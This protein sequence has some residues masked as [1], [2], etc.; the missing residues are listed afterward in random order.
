[1]I[2]THYKIEDHDPDYSCLD[3]ATLQELVKHQRNTV[4]IITG[5][6]ASY[7][8]N[9][10]PVKMICMAVCTDDGYVLEVPFPGD[11]FVNFFSQ[12]IDQVVISEQGTLQ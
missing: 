9:P 6:V 4:H 7:P 10:T 11:D 5:G 3:S 8:G 1:M 12:A 2:R